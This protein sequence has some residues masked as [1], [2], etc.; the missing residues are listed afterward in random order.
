M[1][2][3]EAALAA[4]FEEQANRF[5]IAL[6]N[7]SHGLCMLDDEDHLQVWNERFIELL[8]LQKAPI[9]VGMRITDLVRHSIRAGNHKARSVKTVF[10]DLAG[11]L[12]CGS[13]VEITLA[14][15]V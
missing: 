1:T 5:D 3:K 10:L 2:R 6:N 12:A 8:N 14:A 7:M 4:R 9:R 13:N 15:S 11:R